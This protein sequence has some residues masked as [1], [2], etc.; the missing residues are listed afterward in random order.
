MINWVKVTGFDWDE[1]NARKN[2]EKH[3]VSQAEAEAIFFNEPLLVLEDS[4][5]SQAEARFHALGE[6]D[7]ERLL[8]ITFTLR[9]DDT[10]IRVISARDMHRT[11]RGVYEQAKKDA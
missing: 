10:L 1:G 11:E 7:D 3:G 9:K 6:T 5:H 8:H 2:A 4:K